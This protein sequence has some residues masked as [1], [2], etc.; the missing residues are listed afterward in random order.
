MAYIKVRWTSVSNGSTGGLI[1]E[2]SKLYKMPLTELS[3][4]FPDFIAWRLRLLCNYSDGQTQ[5][6]PEFETWDEAFAYDFDNT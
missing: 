3:G 5:L 4:L 1:I 2:A 6:S